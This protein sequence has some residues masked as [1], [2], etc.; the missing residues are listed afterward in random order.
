MMAN[1]PKKPSRLEQR[2]AALVPEKAMVFY[3]GISSQHSLQSR[4]KIFK[5]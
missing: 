4:R 3:L 1:A 2:E 5:S